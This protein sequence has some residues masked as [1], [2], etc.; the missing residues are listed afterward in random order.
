MTIAKNAG[1]D[2]AMVGVKVET[3]TGDYGY[4]ALKGEY[5]NLIEKSIHP[6]SHLF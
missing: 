6:D 5:G 2:G 1:V 4:D 3:Q